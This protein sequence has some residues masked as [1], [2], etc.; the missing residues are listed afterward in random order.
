[1]EPIKVNEAIDIE[2][3]KLVFLKIEI[4]FDDS[5]GLLKLD[6]PVKIN[7]SETVYT[8]SIAGSHRLKIQ[9]VFACHT[10]KKTFLKFA[11]LPKEKILCL[12]TEQ[13]SSFKTFF[14]E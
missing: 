3:K 11:E 13:D 12:E 4:E 6:T 8:I 5:V 14:D 1:M 9:G 2:T 10:Y 7:S